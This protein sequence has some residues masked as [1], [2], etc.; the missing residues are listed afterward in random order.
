M[1]SRCLR[2]PVLA[3]TLLLHVPVSA[4][5]DVLTVG[6]AGAFPDIQSALDAAADGDA[7]L[8]S[9]GT[10]ASFQVPDLSISIV[11]DI[12]QTV[13]VEGTVSVPNLAAGR[14]LLLSGLEVN[15]AR[16]LAGSEEAFVLSG[17]DGSVR[18]Q[19]SVARG[20]SGGGAAGARAASAVSI[21]GCADVGLS[22]CSLFGGIGMSPSSGGGAGLAVSSG[23]TVSLVEC[24]VQGGRG[25]DGDGDPVAMS[26]SGGNGGHGLSV[27]EALLFVAGSTLNGGDGGDGA[28][29]FDPGCSGT[30]AGPAGDGGSGI[31]VDGLSS[32]IRWRGLAFTPGQPGAEASSDPSCPRPTPAV[33]GQEILVVAGFVIELP[34]TQ[35]T[36]SFPTVLRQGEMT[37]VE[38][39]G[40][41]G[42]FAVGIY[43]LLPEQLWVAGVGQLLVSLDPPV[44]MKFFGSIPAS[45]FLI[46]PKTLP[47]LV[48]SIDSIRFYSQALS[49]NGR[50]LTLGTPIGLVLL[51]QS[52]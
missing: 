20:A 15:G 45:G 23:S 10:Y 5:A 47:V 1:L 22:G 14:T 39:T 35:P 29:F 9:S 33:A 26:F 12:G 30:R 24:D 41:P 50:T 7:V 13:I 21:E 18:I 2:L 38:F 11:S 4:A 37:F 32:R 40:N 3:L 48:P 27:D 16:S 49:V 52:L 51:D 43:H 8:I 44:R 42:D 36:M 19:D 31:R 46:F 34:G 25:A 17:L 28:S 6:A